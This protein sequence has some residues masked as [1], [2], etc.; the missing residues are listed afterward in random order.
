MKRNEIGTDGRRDEPRVTY[1]KLWCRPRDRLPVA[2]LVLR[3]QATADG[4]P[5]MWSAARRLVTQRADA[6]TAGGRT[7]GPGASTRP[8][9][10]VVT[11]P[12]R[13]PTRRYSLY[14]KGPRRVFLV[15]WAGGSSTAE[16]KQPETDPTSKDEAHYETRLWLFLPAHEHLFFF[17]DRPTN[18]SGSLLYTPACSTALK[19]QEPT[20]HSPSF[21]S[22]V[23]MR[24]HTSAIALAVAAAT[25]TLA[26][27]TRS[28]P[29]WPWRRRRR[30]RPDFH[31][32]FFFRLF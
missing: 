8:W 19:R 28:G 12:G 16:N 10:V 7:A 27:S 23:Y 25:S 9:V 13:R 3:L 4:I 29:L 15:W 30:H 18:T 11:L 26:S 20:A 24:A 5:E 2:V 21:R 1:G 17:C 22:A 6:W 32:S 31:A 14:L